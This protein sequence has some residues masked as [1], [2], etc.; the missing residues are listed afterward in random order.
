[1]EEIGQFSILTVSNRLGPIETLSLVSFSFLSV[2]EI[3]QRYPAPFEGVLPP[4]SPM[5][6]FLA[7]PEKPQ[8]VLT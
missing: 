1:M 5:V 3:L 7:V 6:A 8:Q 2:R 4:K